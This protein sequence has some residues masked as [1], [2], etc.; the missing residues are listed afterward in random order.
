MPAVLIIGAGQSAYYLIDYLASRS[1]YRLTVVDISDDR[2]AMV[3]AAFPRVYTLLADMRDPKLRC[4]LI[5]AHDVVVSMLPAHMHSPIWECCLQ[6]RRHFFTASYLSDTL[7]HRAQE[8]AQKGLFF[9]Q[10]M[11]LDPGI[12]HMSAQEEIDRI[13]AEGGW[14]YSFKTYTGGLIA[15]E[16]DNNP[17]HYKFTWNPHNVVT[18]GKD[19]ALFLSKGQIHIVPYHRL[20]RTLDDIYI[21]ELG[22]F[23]A[24]FNRDSLKYRSVFRL[25]SAQTLIRGTLRKKGF[26]AGWDALVQLGLTN[27]SLEIPIIADTSPA[28]FLRSFLPSD[29]T[30]TPL[31]I[32]VARFLGIPPDHRI[33]EMLQWAGL[34]SEDPMQ[35][36][37]SYSPA[38]VLLHLLKSRW[39][40][41]PTD[42]DMIVMVHLFRYQLNGRKLWKKN[43]MFL[44]GKGAH[45][46]AMARTVGLPLAIAVDLF[47]KNH[48]RLRGLYIPNVPEIY[49]PVLRQLHA[50]GIVFHSIEKEI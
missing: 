24:Y 3:N 8:I 5:D 15:P 34:F 23:E 6:L 29:P 47:L 36:E 30:N 44:K 31:V 48:I 38:Q 19:G 9:L 17:W 13:Q 32:Q 33:I 40:M 46:T 35:L 2:L 1:N 14:V 50:E 16:S 22:H 39:K 42:C 43:Y 45:H 27:N 25:D 12:D 21:P 18:A 20:F 37:G 41:E 28:S 49:Q 7:A 26:S 11:G 4:T 10:E